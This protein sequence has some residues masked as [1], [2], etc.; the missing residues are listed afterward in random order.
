MIT[1]LILWLLCSGHGHVIFAPFKVFAVILE[2]FAWILLIGL[3]C[4]VCECA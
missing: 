1:V 3:V 4:L 2:I